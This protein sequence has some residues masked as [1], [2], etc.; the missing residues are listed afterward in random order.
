[1]LSESATPRSRSRHRRRSRC[2]SSRRG[3]RRA[4]ARWRRRR[5]RSARRGG[6]RA[7]SRRHPGKATG[8]ESVTSADPGCAA[9]PSSRNQIGPVPREQREVGEGLDVGDQRGAPAHPA[10]EGPRGGEGGQRGAAAEEGDER[11]LLP[12]D[13]AG[14]HRDQPRVG[15][16][17]PRSVAVETPRSA[18]ASA[19]PRRER[20]VADSHTPSRIS[21]APHG[22]GGEQRAVEHEV[23]EGLQQRAVLGA[24]G[25]ALG[26][27][28]DH[29]GRPPSGDRA[30]PATARSL[31]AGGSRRPPQP[32]RPAAS[33]SSISA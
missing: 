15:A 4:A 23:G 13:V 9:V 12:G 6:S 32:R 31:V 25:L 7:R 24:R 8:P 30:A 33:T 26:A 28:D 17:R 10:F 11:G 27:V 2:R 1:M 21:R 16:R 18:I 5:R 19:Q 29:D 14:G 22:G 20:R 3:A